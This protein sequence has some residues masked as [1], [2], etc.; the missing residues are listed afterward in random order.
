MAGRFETAQLVADG[1]VRG[2]EGHQLGEEGAQGLFRAGLLQQRPAAPDNRFEQAGHRG[3][4][5][6]VL[7]AEGAH[8]GPRAQAGLRGD[9]LDRELDA[10]LG[11]QRRGRL[12]GE[13]PVAHG[14]GPASPPAG[15]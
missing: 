15:S 1:V 5:E 8:N 13:P 2:L 10:R 11:Q 3:V 14:I 6:R 7:A 4:E 9:G 12:Q